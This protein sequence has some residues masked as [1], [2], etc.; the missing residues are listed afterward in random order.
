VNDLAAT[1]VEQ[2]IFLS[3]FTVNKKEGIFF[4]VQVGLNPI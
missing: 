1:E 2:G 4:T 3:T